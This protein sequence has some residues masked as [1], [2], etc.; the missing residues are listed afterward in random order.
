M[1]YK[2][3]STSSSSPNSSWSSLRRSSP[4]M[5]C[6]SSADPAKW[7][8][9]GRASPPPRGF[10]TLTRTKLRLPGRT[11]W[12]GAK[13]HSTANDWHRAL[14]RSTDCLTGSIW[15]NW[16]KDIENQSYC[17]QRF[18]SETRSERHF[19]VTTLIF[20]FHKTTFRLYIDSPY[21][22]IL[23]SSWVFVNTW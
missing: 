11:G 6:P 21:F 16:V 20:H 17:E 13:A 5:G 2:S 19:T 4:P 18:I 10:Q 8:P 9:P 23:W 22:V 1:T 3:S 12:D 14:R 7:L 15:D